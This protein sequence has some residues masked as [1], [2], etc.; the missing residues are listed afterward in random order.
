L[1]GTGLILMPTWLIGEDIRKG[2]LQAVLTDCQVY[3]QTSIDMGIYALYLP[4]RRNS[5]RVKA[6]IDFLI[7]RFG[8]P[9]DWEETTL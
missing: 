8:N 3:P 1:D 6:F 4:N 2:K 5:L 7:K 9:P